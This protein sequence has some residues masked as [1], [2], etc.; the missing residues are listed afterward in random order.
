[1]ALLVF[2]LHFTMFA[3]NNISLNLSNTTVK[4]AI[5][6]L[7]KEYGYSFT[8]ES[9]DINTQKVISINLQN[10]SVDEAVKQILQDQ[11]V[12]YEIKNKNIVVRKK[13]P[14]TTKTTPVQQTITVTGSVTE[15]DGSPMIG[16]N[17]AVKGTT[18]GT[19]TDVDGKYSISVPD[20]KTTLV[21]SYLGYTA[22]EIRVGSQRNINIT[23]KENASLLEEVVVVG[24]GIQKKVNLTGAV[25]QITS[26]IFENRPV[27]NTTQALIGA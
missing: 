1:M 19:V 6:T 4:N 9:G 13:A 24:Y 15:A 5:E 27:T 26:K 2:C 3:Q 18:S 20:E 10:K 12:L 22:Q 21:F 8:F 7:M 17:V 14:A 11:D 16:V 25:D 23:L